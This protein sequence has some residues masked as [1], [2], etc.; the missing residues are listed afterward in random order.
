[1]SLSEITYL[2]EHTSLPLPPSVK[3]E[4]SYYRMMLVSGLCVRW[5]LNTD[6]TSEQSVCLILLARA[7]HDLAKPLGWDWEPPEPDKPSFLH[8]L[9]CKR[10]MEEDTP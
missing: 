1:M 4:L 6:A 2:L 9:A 7:L 10:E 5:A 8:Y 3:E